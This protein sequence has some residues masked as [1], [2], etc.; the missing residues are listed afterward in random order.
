MID[1]SKFVAPPSDIRVNLRQP[2]SKGGFTYA[3][4]GAIIVRVAYRPDV[5]EKDDAPNVEK[6]FSD[7]HTGAAFKPLPAVKW[8]KL[9]ETKKQECRSCYGRGTE[10]DCPDCE[11]ECEDCDGTGTETVNIIATVSVRGATFKA[12][13]IK[14]ISELPDCEFVTFSKDYAPNPFRFSG[15]IG[16]I[17]SGQWRS[18]FCH[19]GDI[20]TLGKTTEAV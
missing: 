5:L 14:M 4:D 3:T 16:L 10:H 15:G 17:M 11:C 19:L 18:N 6:L 12:R 2:F 8:G 20:E 13:Y 9:S 7:H 1:L